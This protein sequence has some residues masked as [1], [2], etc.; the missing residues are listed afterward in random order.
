MNR[1]VKHNDEHGF[2]ITHEGRIY[3]PLIATKFDEGD[4]VTIKHAPLDSSYMTITS[5]DGATVEE[6]RDTNV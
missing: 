4:S 1:I 3:K 2:H 6:W 5:E